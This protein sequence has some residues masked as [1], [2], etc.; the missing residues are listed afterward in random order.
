MTI[1]AYKVKKLPI[2]QQSINVFQ[3]MYK[4]SGKTVVT[5]S[6]IRQ[7]A[8]DLQQQVQSKLDAN[9]LDLQGQIM[10]TNFYD[11]SI[12]WQSG[13]F[14]DF[15][16]EV[17][18]YDFESEYEY[19]GDRIQ[20]TFGRFNLL[21]KLVPKA[22]GCDGELNDCLWYC[23]RDTVNGDVSLMPKS[24]NTP[25]RLKKYLKVTRDD[26]IAVSLMPLIEEKMKLSIHVV[27]D[28][29]VVSMT[30]H[31]KQVS[32]TLHNGHFSVAKRH[33][34]QEQLVGCTNTK[35]KPIVFF[36]EVY[37]DD[38]SVSYVAYDG[39]RKV[40][41]ERQVLNA[42]WLRP[43]G[44]KHIYRATNRGKTPLSME[45]QHK[46]YLFDAQELKAKS[47]GLINLFRQ[48]NEKKAACY[49]FG[50]LSRNFKE[51]AP[52][53]EI[54]GRWIHN[55]R[56]GGLIKATPITLEQAWCYD[57]NKFYSAAMVDA[58]FTFPTAKGEWHTFTKE[59]FSSLT[60][61]KYGMY[62]C[63]ITNPGGVDCRLFML[64]EKSYHTHF[65]LTTAKE[66]GL[67][68]ELI[69]DGQP[70]ACL[71]TDR[72]H[73]KA[74]F[75]PFID[76]M[77][78]LYDTVDASTKPRVKLITNSLWGG[79]CQHNESRVDLNKEAELDLNGKEIVHIEPYKGEF[80]VNL[81]TYT[82]RYKT[83]YARL[84][85]FITSFARRKMY[86]HLLPFQ[87]HVHRVHTDGV[88]VDK[89]VD[90]PIGAK[91]GEWKIEHEGRCVIHNVN[92]VTWG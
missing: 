9:N 82:K 29:E 28:M 80:L 1:K 79:L 58:K 55:T 27:G 40:A 91:M 57:L 60:F 72:V 66:I 67:T 81:S 53:G 13:K 42:F 47:K 41:I 32:V 59:E 49:A 63:R 62:K 90:L 92:N 77:M 12:A 3:Y 25:K 50:K 76:V 38:S 16:K 23:L 56:S 88:I 51:P 78:G 24:I 6:D 75:G 34:V 89:P 18:F 74:L 86:Q 22:G 35:D 30:D 31:K 73:G 10:V 48:L 17:D 4:T 69:V 8:K 83:D 87:Q 5:N 14:T 71:Y 65:T 20:S 11:K 45:D 19:N 37:G 2:K 70:N 44:C 15:G 46:Q 54:E 21:V 7:K 36:D 84:G 68:I 64:N 85:P 33:R 52:I 61:F 26:Q 43:R 39:V